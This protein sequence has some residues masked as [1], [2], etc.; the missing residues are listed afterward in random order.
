MATV[1]QTEWVGEG[2]VQN[3]PRLL[4]PRMLAEGY[5]PVQEN[6]GM[7]VFNRGKKVRPKLR[8]W[9]SVPTDE[10]IRKS[11]TLTISYVLTPQRTTVRFAW[12][13]PWFPDW[14]PQNERNRV[15]EE[16]KTFCAYLD[17]WWAAQRKLDN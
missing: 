5:C 1:H 2:F 17:D 11:Y 3:L 16:A 8:W 9:Q 15:L 4:V 13:N 10:D 14:L 12:D 6:E 7:Q